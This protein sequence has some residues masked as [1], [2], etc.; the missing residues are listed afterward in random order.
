MIENMETTEVG[1]EQNNKGVGRKKYEIE[2]TGIDVS[3]KEFRPKKEM[4]IKSDQAVIF[5]TGW[6]VDERSKSVQ[7]LAQA[8][9]DH[10]DGAALAVQTR[11]DVNIPESLRKQAEA[12]REMI[13]E[14]EA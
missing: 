11:P 5:L 7:D 14:R 10:S 2:G 13:R 1:L 6:G 9:A 3:W 12:I 4:P 8:F